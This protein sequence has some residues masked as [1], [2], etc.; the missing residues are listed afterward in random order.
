MLGRPLTEFG[1][2]RPILP[3]PL[4]RVKNRAVRIR[5]HPNVAAGVSTLSGGPLTEFGRGRPN[6]GSSPP[7]GVRGRL[8]RV[9]PLP[10][11]RVKDGGLG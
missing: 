4:E 11:E 5:L 7:D 2:R 3:L 8:G 6:S 1:R 9:L 10:L